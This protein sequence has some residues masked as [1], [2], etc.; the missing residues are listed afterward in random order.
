MWHELGLCCH[1]LLFAVDAVRFHR[2]VKRSH[3][4]AE[5]MRVKVNERSQDR[6]SVCG[7]QEAKYGCTKI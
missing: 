7:R 1:C 2:Q 4:E 6:A 3:F 5:V